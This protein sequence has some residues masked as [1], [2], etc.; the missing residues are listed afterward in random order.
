MSPIQRF[1]RDG[2]S[3]YVWG[4]MALA[5]IVGLVFAITNGAQVLD[6]ERAVSEARAVRYVDRVLAPRLDSVD[7][8]ETITG[9]SADSLEA[10]VSLL[11]LTDDRV[12]RVRIW[13]SADEGML[14]FSTDRDDPI[15]IGSEASLNDPVL[16]AAAREG[17]ISP[18]GLSDTGGTPD[19]ERSLFRTY[20]PLRD[21]AVVEIDQS[22]EG[23]I[24]AIRSEWRSYQ[25]LAGALTLLFLFMSALSLRDPIQRINV[26]V[27]PA[28]SIPAG[29]SL[30]D[31]DRLHAVREVYRLS[32]ERV[33]RLQE[34]LSE[35]EEARR[36]LEGDIQRALVLAES[37][38][39]RPA[40]PAPPA[41][42]STVTETAIVQVPESEVVDE[43]DDDRVAASASGLAAAPRD[44]QPLPPTPPKETPAGKEPRR[45][46]KQKKARQ[47][48]PR[49]PSSGN[50]PDLEIRDAKAHAAALENFLR[51]ADRD[52]QPDDTVD[53]GAVRALSPAAA[54]KKLLAER[55][56]PP[57]QEE[58]AGD[59]R[60]G[61]D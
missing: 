48:S 26:G 4:G 9:E 28:A 23:T 54:R 38:V 42:P 39:T 35:S 33:K 43:V 13:A 15:D 59:P 34:K 53:H 7:L 27:A 32:A 61:T 11:I 1:T 21:G 52:R 6:E 20:A 8:T 56:K 57:P 18:S 22:D 19:A 24:A 49:A 37:S 17:P 12:E 41:A 14:L 36:R 31:N 16:K 2:V 51:L 50:A 60:T 5:A 40:A 46:P 58:S 55:L 47:E 25:I 3:R 45:A 30:I 10:Y 44:Q 29:F